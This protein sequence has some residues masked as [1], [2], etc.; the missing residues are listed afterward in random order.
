[1]GN[2]PKDIKRCII[3]MGADHGGIELK[4]D[5]KPLLRELGHEVRDLG[6]QGPEPVHY[7]VFAAQVSGQLVASRADRGILICG[8]GIGMSIVANRFPGVRAALCHDLYTALMSRKHNDANC[9]VMGG[10]V[11]GKGL[12]REIVKIWLDTPFEGE[13]HL[14]R[15]DLIQKVEQEILRIGG[16]SKAISPNP[17]RKANQERR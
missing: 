4:E 5:L 9:L 10:R 3:A 6:P 8:T 13:R 14:E 2:R 11:V 12:A 15:L 1:M 17:S 7:P 16:R